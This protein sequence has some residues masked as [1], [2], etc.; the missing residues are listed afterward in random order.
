M[1]A[2]LIFDLVCCAEWY[3]PFLTIAMHIKKYDC[4]W[5]SLESCVVGMDMAV[6]QVFFLCMSHTCSVAVE[7]LSG[8][9][10][11]WV[12]IGSGAEV[13]SY[14]NQKLAPDACI[15]ITIDSHKVSGNFAL[16]SCY[17]S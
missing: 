10:V 16:D 17:D 12:M 1:N 15:V 13:M 2:C 14:L 5:M 4:V 3:V 7:L 11:F 6:R 9:L 8:Q